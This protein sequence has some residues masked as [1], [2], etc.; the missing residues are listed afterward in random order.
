M[1]LLRQL[2]ALERRK[3]GARAPEGQV[4]GLAWVSSEELDPWESTAGL[5]ADVYEQQQAGELD[6]WR[7]VLR[8]SEGRG[9]LGR[10]YSR[11]GELVGHVRRLDGS[12]IEIEPVT[13]GAVIGAGAGAAGPG[14]DDG[15]GLAP[16]PATADEPPLKV[17]RA[18]AAPA[19]VRARRQA[20]PGGVRASRGRLKTPEASNP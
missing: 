11:E 4:I 8:Q 13:A 17:R 6:R 14:G 19:A 7:L 18:A 3:A 2:Q 15:G 10:V 1:R 16:L 12:L 5:V 9:D 20:P